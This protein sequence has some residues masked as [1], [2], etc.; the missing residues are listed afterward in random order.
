MNAARAP[1][2]AAGAREFALLGGLAVVWSSSFVA[3]KLGVETIPPATLAAGRL[4]IAALL[5]L[6]V[7]AAGRR[8]LPLAPRSVAIYFFVGLFG[9]ALPFSMIGWGET[10]VDSGLAA[11]LMGAMP[12]ATAVLAHFFTPEDR[13]TPRRLI[14]T[15]LGLSGIFVLI[16]WQ[17]L[18]GLGRDVVAQ[19]ALVGGAV[20][21]AITTVF[22]R[23]YG[24]LPGRVMAAGAMLAGALLSGLL[25]LAT[26]HPWTLAPSASSWL[27]LIYLGLLPTAAAALVYFHLIRKI[28]ATMFS[29]INFVLPAMGAVWG[30][31]LLGERIGLNAWLALA[32][33]AVGVALVNSRRSAPASG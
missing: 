10:V 31:V 19:L 7:L 25:A 4:G 29:Q 8:R 30:A 18:G 13:L 23:R 21:Y 14:G 5:L 32:L 6:A 20:C 1:L 26:E 11:I 2:A 17:A 27:A 3:I 15:L 24:N 22:V 33:I 9:N 16:G 28:G 12:V